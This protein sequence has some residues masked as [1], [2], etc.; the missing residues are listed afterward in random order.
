MDLVG[1]SLASRSRAARGLPYRAISARL[2]LSDKTVRNHVSNVLAKTGASDRQAAADMARQASP[3]GDPNKHSGNLPR[4][5]R[6]S[7]L[8]RQ[9]P[10][11]AVSQLR[12]RHRGYA[13]ALAQGPGQDLRRVDYLV[14]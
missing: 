2:C 8:P 1:R 9:P 13:S 6:H 14:M 5:P 10:R 4:P 7:R 11:Q 3:G 12:T